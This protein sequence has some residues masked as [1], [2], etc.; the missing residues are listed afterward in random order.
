MLC[1]GCGGERPV[2]RRVGMGKAAAAYADKIVL[3][4][5]NHEVKALIISIRILVQILWQKKS[6]GL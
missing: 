4:A 2:Q 1:F 3:T 6:S 5:D